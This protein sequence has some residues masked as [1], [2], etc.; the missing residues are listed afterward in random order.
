M[1][2]ALLK[3]RR[4]Q[5][6]ANVLSLLLLVAVTAFFPATAIVLAVMAPLLGCPLIGRREQWAAWLAA[7]TPC[8]ATLISGG[9]WLLALMLMLPGT[10]CM[11]CTLWLRSQKKLGAPMAAACYTAAYAASLTLVVLAA[12]HALGAPLS[13]ALS[14]LI[15]S[16][17]EGSSQPGVLLYRFASAGLLSVPKAYRQA[18]LLLNLL[19]PGLIRQMLLSLRLTLTTAFAQTLPTLFVQ[20]CL[21]GGLF[22]ALRVQKLNCAVLVVGQ[23]ADGEKKTQVMQPPGFR[24]L[25]LPRRGRGVLIVLA[26]C[27]LLPFFAQGALI[28]TLSTLCYAAFCCVFQLLGA[29]VAV[30]MLSARHPER[31]PLFGVLA[32]VCYVLFPTAL[33]LIGVVD[34]GLHFRAALLKLDDHQKEDEQP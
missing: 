26:L 27:S 13:Q 31:A 22:T 21:L 32:G 23:T 33:F 1:Q 20:L 9:N 30:C 24:L 4:A 19:D 17:V 14:D 2:S 3:P 28:D 16:R 7:L 18:N 25:A 29:A 10:S 5:L 12:S 8:A 34:Q 11:G 6:T 15:V